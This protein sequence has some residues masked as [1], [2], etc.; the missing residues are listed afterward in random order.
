M[1]NVPNNLYIEKN[2]NGNLK[3]TLTLCYWKRQ[4][5]LK[6]N[7]TEAEKEEQYFST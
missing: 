2:L 4:Y 3:L 6:F 7:L 1:N 5:S